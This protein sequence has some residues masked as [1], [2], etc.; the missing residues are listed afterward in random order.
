MIAWDSFD[1]YLFDID[2]TLLHCR[3]AVH[4]YGFCEVL[5]AT[6]RR[7]MTLEG[8]NA[9]G[10]VDMGIVRDAM[11][12]AGIADSEWRDQATSMEAALSLFVEQRSEQLSIDVM[13]GVTDVLGHLRDKGATLG[14][15]TGNL[16]RIGWAKLER[17]RLRPWFQ[18]G[19][20]SD[21][22]EYRADVVHAAIL[23]ARK[24]AGVDASLCLVGDTPADIRA[25]RAN[26]LPVIAVSSGIYSY[27]EL[28]TDAPD[29]LVR[30]MVELV[31]EAKALTES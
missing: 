31:E 30:S 19:G 1:A 4:Y 8:V 11:R 14:V 9:H 12:V 20:F 18:F 27:E 21:G 23:K 10:N 5:S 26:G 17:C 7:P 22:Y 6:A 16:E 3:D 28:V 25:A 13:P 24:L 15:A 29:F 2:G